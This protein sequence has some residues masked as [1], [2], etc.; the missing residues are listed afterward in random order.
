[1]CLFVLF[2]SSQSSPLRAEIPDQVRYDGEVLS[3]M[4]Y[5]TTV[6]FYAFGGGYRIKSGMTG[7]GV[8]LSYTIPLTLTEMGIP[9]CY[10]H[11]TRTI[12]KDT[13]PLHNNDRSLAGASGMADQVRHDD[14]VVCDNNGIPLALTAVLPFAPSAVDPRCARM[15][16]YGIPLSY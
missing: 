14:C 16:T 7:R 10:Y 4:L 13:I 15:T 11:T 8:P 12:D 6:T 9:L 3:T 1:M 2:A 5:H